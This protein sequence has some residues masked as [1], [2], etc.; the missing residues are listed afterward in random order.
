MKV[1]LVDDEKS[2]RDMLTSFLEDLKYEVESAGT[3]AEGL[4]KVESFKP[5]TILLDVNLPDGTGLDFLSRYQ[6]TK[7]DGSV[8]LITANVDVKIAV[9]AIKRGAEDYLAKP[10][11]LDELEIILK[12]LDE[13]RGMRRDLA[14]LKAHQKANYQ[15]DYLFLSNPAMQKVYEQ[16]E[17][18]AEQSSVTVLITGE[19]GTGKEHAAKLIH[20]LSARTA[21]PFMELHC[22]AMPETLLESELF[23]Y[24]QGAFT[25][26]RRSKPGLFEVAN[27]G[28]VFLD[29][30]GELPMTVQTKLLKVL[31]QKMIRRL[32]GIQENKINVRV[33]AATNRDLKQEVQEGRFRADLFYRLN[34]VNVV[35]PPLTSRPED[36]EGL[37]RFFFADFSKEFNKKLRPLSNEILKSLKAY[38]WPGNVRELK[39]AME[40]AVLSTRG[41]ALAVKDFP[42]EIFEPPVAK[43]KTAGGPKGALN[44]EDA[45]KE[46]IQQA[47]LTFKGHKTKV[48][49]YLGV[50]RTTLLSK[51]KKY[52]LE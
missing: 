45:E 52:R 37:A 23:G 34:V 10:L 24:E 43:P 4:E 36:V 38:H 5:N 40:R 19:T 15:K 12:Q 30:V 46:N 32:G 2:I 1:L 26:A 27:G 47:L 14:A 41:E 33:V 17:Q 39:N 20:V 18:V 51:I 49:K 9:E 6:E 21:A 11:N 35:L 50:S 42:S 44:R 29:E 28:T 25:D 13:K 48:A 16:I 8:V 31:E 22:G 3:V 7:G